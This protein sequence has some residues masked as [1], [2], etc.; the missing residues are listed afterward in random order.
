[1]DY[2]RHY[3]KL[4]ETRKNRPLQDGVYYEKHH[5][6]PKALG[7]TNTP[8]N[9]VHLTAREHYIAHW[10]LYR[11]R[12]HSEKLSLAFWMMSFPGS[13]YVERTYR[14]S[15]RAYAEAKEALA[16]ANRK[17]NT[18][19]KIKPE[20]LVKWTKN[21]NNS[22]VV[23]NEVTGE[24]YTNAKQLWR[25]RFSDDITYSAFNY[26]LRGKIKGASVNRKLN[27]TDIYNWKYKK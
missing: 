3:I 25:D 9:I 18:G 17:L 6:I 23:V 16:E 10:L 24:E 13:Q 27:N 1:M 20:H 4:I 19:R 12:P 22:K 21:K 7:G 14:I 2:K 15:S 8:N 26:Y 11:I 5:I